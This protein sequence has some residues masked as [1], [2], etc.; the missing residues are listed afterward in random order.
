MRTFGV[1]ILVSVTALAASAGDIRNVGGR[2]V[3]LQPIHDWKVDKRGERPFAHWKDVLVHE[4]L[5]KPGGWDRC[6]VEIDGKHREILVANLPASIGTFLDAFARRLNTIKGLRA[7]LAADEQ[8]AH[9]AANRWLFTEEGFTTVKSGTSGFYV[10]NQDTRL[11]RML[12]L[13]RRVDLERKQLAALEAE[14]AKA[15][16]QSSEALTVLAMFTGRTYAKLEVWD[17]GLRR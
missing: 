5:D 13:D 6:R 14:Q 12:E 1:F 4:V 16:R 15:V 7:Q 10:D 9:D 8:A 3:D 17:T 11:S 2:S